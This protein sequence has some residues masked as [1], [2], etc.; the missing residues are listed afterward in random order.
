MLDMA[1]AVERR[2]NGQLKIEVYPNGQLTRQ[3]GTIEGLA[4]GVIDLAVENV[5]FL[6]SIVPQYQIFDLPFLFKDLESGYRALDGPI[7][8]EL[9]SYLEPK[10]IVGLCWGVNGF[11]SSR[12]RFIRS[13]GPP[14]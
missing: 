5:S 13:F 8:V 9:F 4:S 3:G 1:A 11:K 6:E 14:T 2:S 10:N 12:R 7:G